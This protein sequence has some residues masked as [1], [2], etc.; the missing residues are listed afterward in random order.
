[1]PCWVPTPVH[2]NNSFSRN[3]HER[4][5]KVDRPPYCT[6]T[7]ASRPRCRWLAWVL[8]VAVAPGAVVGGENSDQRPSNWR[9]W[10]GLWFHKNGAPRFAAGPYYDTREHQT[11]LPVCPPLTEPNFGYY[12]PCWRQLHVYPRCVTC[13]TMPVGVIRSH[14]SVE[15]GELPPAP[16]APPPRDDYAPPASPDTP[17]TPPVIPRTSS[18]AQPDNALDFQ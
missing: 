16:A 17:A 14:R 9:W 6:R 13:E 18:T 2:R 5:L 4:N 10:H 8:V 12:Q 3:T 1:M 15:A 7:R 11:R